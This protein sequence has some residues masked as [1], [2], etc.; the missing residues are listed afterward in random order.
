MLIKG[1]TT[2]WQKEKVQT[3]INKTLHRKLKQCAIFLG[4]NTI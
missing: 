2:Q 1:Q 3:A 4:Q